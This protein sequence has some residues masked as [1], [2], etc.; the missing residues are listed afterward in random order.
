ME[1]RKRM[2]RT[3]AVETHIDKT[4]AAIQ[5]HSLIS[6]QALSYSF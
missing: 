1:M 4:E 3:R 5:R 2:E 6:S